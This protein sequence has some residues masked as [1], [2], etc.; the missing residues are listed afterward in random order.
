MTIEQFNISMYISKSINPFKSD[1]EVWSRALAR[2][3]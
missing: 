1:D 2:P 3:K